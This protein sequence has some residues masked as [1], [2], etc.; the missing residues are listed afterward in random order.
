MCL[1]VEMKF[2]RI[3]L[4]MTFTQPALQLVLAIVHLQL[5]GEVA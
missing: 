3:F 5:Y 4:A 1:S 2:G